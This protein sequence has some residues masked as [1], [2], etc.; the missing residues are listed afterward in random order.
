MTGKGWK[1]IADELRAE[2]DE[3]RAENDQLRAENDQLRAEVVRD[4]FPRDRFPRLAN[5][6]EEM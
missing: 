3:L 5:E 2:N 1:K 6:L 4:R